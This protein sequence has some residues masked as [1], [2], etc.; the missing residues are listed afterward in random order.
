VQ[1]VHGPD[2]DPVGWKKN[3]KKKRSAETR[4][5]PNAIPVGMTDLYIQWDMYPVNDRRKKPDAELP[6]LA[7]RSDQLR[8]GRGMF[9]GFERKILIMLRLIGV[10]G[11]IM[12][13]QIIVDTHTRLFHPMLQIVGDQTRKFEQFNSVRPGEQKT[14]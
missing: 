13:C 14:Q 8:A 11:V 6:N 2:A 7:G 12:Q 1:K 4:G 10:P 5:L 3:E 9:V